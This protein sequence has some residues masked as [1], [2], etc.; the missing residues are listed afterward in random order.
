MIAI[1][2]CDLRMAKSVVLQQPRTVLIKAVADWATTKT[3]LVRA[4]AVELMAV[5]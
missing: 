5:L 3:H 4:T 1:G 2:V